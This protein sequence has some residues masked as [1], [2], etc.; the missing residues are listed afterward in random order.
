MIDLVENQKHELSE[1]C[2]RFKVER[3]DIFGSAADGCFAP[4]QSDLDFLVKF[5]DRRPTGDYANRY[6]DFADALER[7]FDRHVDLLTEQ[8]IRNPFL[9]REIEA[10]RQVVYEESHS[11]AAV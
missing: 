2:R 8:S 4:E 1:L 6:L 3:L 7:V 9:R 10:T 5:S 11:E